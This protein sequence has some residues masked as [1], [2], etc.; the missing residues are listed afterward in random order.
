MR[1]KTIRIIKST[2]IQFRFYY[3]CEEYAQ[4]KL[5]KNYSFFVQSTYHSDYIKGHSL[6][7]A[8][9]DFIGLQLRVGPISVFLLTIVHLWGFPA[10]LG[11]CGNNF[12]SKKFELGC[13]EEMQ[14]S[15]ESFRSD[16]DNTWNVIIDIWKDCDYVWSFKMCCCS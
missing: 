14:L 3:F 6:Y 1:S 15:R 11:C 7:L 4:I 5:K 9:K 2:N 10:A 8:K 12:G 16:D 13:V